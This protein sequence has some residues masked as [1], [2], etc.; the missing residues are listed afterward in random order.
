MI[1]RKIWM[2]ECFTV[3]TFQTFSR[4]F[5][6]PGHFYIRSL[7]EYLTAWSR[8]DSNFPKFQH[9]V[10]F[11]HLACRLD[12]FVKSIDIFKSPCNFHTQIF[13]Q[14]NC[15]LENN[16]GKMQKNVTP[17]FTFAFFVTWLIRRQVISQF[18]LILMAP[19][20]PTLAT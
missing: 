16:L 1:S 9:C 15:A 18:T 4:K 20:F 7:I 2:T 12:F 5:V 17:L 19:K 8:S 3:S 10:R 13:C 14:T 11:S 6:L